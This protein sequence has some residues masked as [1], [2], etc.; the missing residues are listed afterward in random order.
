[1]HTPL[2]HHTSE[3]TVWKELCVGVRSLGR[4]KERS[5][6]P[7]KS[8]RHRSE[9]PSECTCACVCEHVRPGVWDLSTASSFTPWGTI[10]TATLFTE[11]KWR[12]EQSS[13]AWG[14]RRPKVWGLQALASVLFLAY[15]GQIR[16]GSGLGSR[17]KG[18]SGRLPTRSFPRS[19][20]PEQAEGGHEKKRHD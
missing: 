20:T 8:R 1:M 15:P 5:R 3:H 2:T 10:L 9:W 18:L 11:G 14:G 7:E 17:G 4:R 12:P 6:R 19:W 16:T 13:W